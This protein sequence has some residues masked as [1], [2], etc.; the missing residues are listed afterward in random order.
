M[1]V[2]Y[3]YRTSFVCA[4]PKCH[5]HVSGL[6]LRFTSL[7][8]FI[9]NGN[10]Y[11]SE[12][13]LRPQLQAFLSNSLSGRSYAVSHR[14]T[15][16]LILLD[17]SVVTLPQLTE[18]LNVKKNGDP[19]FLGDILIGMGY[20]TEQQVT[21][22]LSKQ[23][24][25][26]WIDVEERKIPRRLKGMVPYEVVGSSALFPIEYDQILNELSLLAIAPLKRAAVDAVQHIN[27]CKIN[28]FIG[29]ESRIRKLIRINYPESASADTLVQVGELTLEDLYRYRE[30]LLT[31]YR[32]TS[33]I[34]MDIAAFGP[35]FWI[36][37][38]TEK[39][40]RDKFT[41]YRRPAESRILWQP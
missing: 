11:C 40:E 22:A 37:M 7:P 33:S 5:K 17:L 6:L 14:N 3:P 21:L 23:E 29:T 10:R 18:A 16:G 30:D 39:E 28:L 26:P 8:S 2:P 34:A 24:G 4:A 25:L 27:H 9:L 15:V 32:T 1:S 13:C 12:N 36:R 31:E 20:A 19:R 38:Y 35:Y 41:V